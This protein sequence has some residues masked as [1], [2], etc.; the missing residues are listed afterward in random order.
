MKEFDQLP[1]KLPVN[2]GFEGLKIYYIK[3]FL[4]IALGV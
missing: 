1:V 4:F 2:I 3:F